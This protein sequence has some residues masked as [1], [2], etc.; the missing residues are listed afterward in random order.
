MILFGISRQ[1]TTL[2]EAVKHNE[3]TFPNMKQNFD[4]NFT[5]Q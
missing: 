5:P 1:G 2:Y 4:F 3:G